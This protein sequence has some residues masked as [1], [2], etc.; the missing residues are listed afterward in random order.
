MLDKYHR[1]QTKAG[2]KLRS[3][4]IENDR[5][6]SRLDQRWVDRHGL[7]DNYTFDKGQTDKTK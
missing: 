4:C 5:F 2:S 6:M 7:C 3:A 1:K